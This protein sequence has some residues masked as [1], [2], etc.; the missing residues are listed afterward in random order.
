M[1]LASANVIYVNAGA[2]RP[3]EVWLDALKSGGRIILPLT[4]S[5]APGDSMTQ[6][7]IF[8]I[9]RHTDHYSARCMSSTVIYPCVGARD[10]A[11][12][13]ALA[14]AFQRG[15]WDKVRRLYRTD[16][17]PKECCWVRAPSWSLAY[18]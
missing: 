6:G 14:E 7:A 12:E 16:E 17:I 5:G 2:T 11:S 1:P 15:G 3:A 13:T 10:K 9:E 18:E 8:L 4:V